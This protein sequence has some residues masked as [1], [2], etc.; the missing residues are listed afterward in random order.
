[1]L[2]VLRK[3][4]DQPLPLAYMISGLVTTLVGR[5]GSVLPLSDARWSTDADILKQGIESFSPA[6][7]ER[8]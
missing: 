7:D 1:M 6:E 5:F 2:Q 3:L 8:A 4:E